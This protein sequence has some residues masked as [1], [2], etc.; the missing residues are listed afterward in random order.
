MKTERY[1]IESYSELYTQGIRKEPLSKKYEKM[2]ETLGPSKGDI[3]LDI[4]TGEGRLIP[5]IVKEKPT[6]VG[7]DISRKMLL[8]A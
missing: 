2:I 8:Y 6:Y 3:I 4:G 7:T 1:F 5:L